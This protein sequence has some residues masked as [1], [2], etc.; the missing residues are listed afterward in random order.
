MQNVVR[1]AP[2]TAGMSSGDVAS[3]DKMRDLWQQMRVEVAKVIIGQQDVIEQL[4]ICILARGPAPHVTHFFT[5][6]D[7]SSDLGR[8]L[9][10]ISTAAS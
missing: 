8:V 5:D 4:L 6:S 2:N 3:I 10:T 9:R 7:A 1:E